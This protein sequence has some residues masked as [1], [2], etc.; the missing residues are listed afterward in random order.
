MVDFHVTADPSH[1]DESA[2]DYDLLNEMNSRVINQVL[3]SILKQYQVKNVLDLTC[4][5]GSQVFWLKKCGFNVTGSDF[6]P[7]MLNIAKSKASDKG[8]D[9]RFI[10]GDMRSLQ[11]GKF[12]AVITIFNAIGHLTKKDFEVAVQNVYKNLKDNGVY[13][14]D[15]FNLNYLLHGDN[16]TKLTIDWLKDN[17]GK[18]VREI[19]YS[20]IDEE[21]ILASYTTSIVLDGSRQP[22]VSEKKQTLQVYSASQIEDLLKRCGFE[23]IEQLGADGAK[24]DDFSTERILTV[25]RK[26]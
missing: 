9:V 19:Q 12:D 10:E 5:T 25:A 21:G 20:T 26:I 16:I 6:N 14:F 13:I 15:I 24:F 4:G 22:N 8:I 11:V 3:E 7:E 1:Y 23:T 2:E 18:K 17:D